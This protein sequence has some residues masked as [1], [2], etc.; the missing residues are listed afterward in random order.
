MK[1]VKVK[2]IG[3]LGMLLGLCLSSQAVVL[4]PGG[5]GLDEPQAVNPG[6]VVLDELITPFS[7]GGV[8]GTLTSWVVKNPAN[9]LGGLSFYYQVSNTGTEALSRVSTSD[10]GVVPGSPVDVSTITGA[11]DSSVTGGVVPFNAS[12]ST[13]AGSVVGFNFLT[14]MV[15]PGQSSVVMVVDT[16]YSA[17][18]MSAGAISDSSS[19]NVN[20]LGPV[21]EPSTFM[22]AG[23]LLIPFGAS[24]LRIVRKH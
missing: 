5:V 14:S 13:G 10:F 12:R 2:I 15:Q 8:S 20:I 21:P 3:A 22:A 19:V 9:P 11:F 6:T 7:F 23:L 16:A 18:T 4:P 17:F 24:L 1:T